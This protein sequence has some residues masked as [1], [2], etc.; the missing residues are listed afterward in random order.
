MHPENLLEVKTLIFRWL[1]ALVYSEQ[2]A[3]ELDGNES[4]AITSLYF[5][6]AKF[7]LYSEKVDRRPEASSLRL[8][9]YDQLSSRPEIFVEQKTADAKGN[10]QESRFSIKDKWVKPFLDGAYGME[11]S[12]QKMER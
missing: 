10:S 12:V 4:P 2:S 9:W 11:K 1:S 3:K 6:N 7:E 5:D 8:R